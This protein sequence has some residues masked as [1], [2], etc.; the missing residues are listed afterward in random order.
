VLS[1]VAECFYLFVYTMLLKRT[2]PQN[3][4][5]GGAAGGV[6]PGVGHRWRAPPPV[7][8]RRFDQKGSGRADFAAQRKSLYQ[9]E[10]H[11][12]DWGRDPDLGIGRGQHK[13]QD[14]R[15]HQREG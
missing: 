14:G 7:G 1:L 12:Q 5:I 13:P 8:R 11:Q 15:A 10:N 9:A 3:I 2:T 4:V 6:P